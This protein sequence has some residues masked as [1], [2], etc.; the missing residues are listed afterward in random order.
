MGVKQTNVIYIGLKMG[1]EARPR[2]EGMLKKGLCVRSQLKITKHT[3]DHVCLSDP[4]KPV[5]PSNWFKSSK[6]KAPILFLIFPICFLTN[7]A[8]TARSSKMSLTRPQLLS[9]LN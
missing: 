1:C 2:P 6:L 4:V 7:T 8:A 5:W 3:L 9:I